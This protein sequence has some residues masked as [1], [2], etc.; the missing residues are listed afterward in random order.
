MQRDSFVHVQTPTGRSLGF[1]A[2]ISPVRPSAAA[3]GVSSHD[4]KGNTLC[5]IAFTFCNKKDKH[6]C[7]KIAR[8]QLW[9]KQQDMVKVRNLP[10]LLAEAEY[11]A[12][13]EHE[14]EPPTKEWIS[15]YNYVLRRFV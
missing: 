4:A 2:M 7:K 9:E 11:K 1:S 10:R 14:F 3:G 8:E 15:K 12:W 13:G 5:W 6:F